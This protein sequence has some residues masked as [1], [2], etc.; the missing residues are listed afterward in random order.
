MVVYNIKYLCFINGLFFPIDNAN[1]SIEF[2]ISFGSFASECLG[3][4]FFTY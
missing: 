4:K 3:I 2:L 1:F